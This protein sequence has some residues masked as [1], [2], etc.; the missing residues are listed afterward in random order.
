MFNIAVINEQLINI[1]EKN[2]PYCHIFKYTTFLI[3]KTLFTRSI[4]YTQYTV[5]IYLV[6]RYQVYQSTV[7]TQGKHNT[8]NVLYTDN[9][10]YDKYFNCTT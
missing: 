9:R 6:A 4:P 2:I 5:N 1:F 7:K 10:T 8:R 3:F